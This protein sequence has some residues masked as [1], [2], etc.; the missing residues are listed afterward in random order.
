[1]WVSGDILSNSFPT[2]VY[3]YIQKKKFKAI[4]HNL[5]YVKSIFEDETDTKTALLDWGLAWANY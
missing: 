5:F 2:L 1:M 4:L 3:H